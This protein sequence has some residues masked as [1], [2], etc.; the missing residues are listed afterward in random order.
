MAFDY[1]TVKIL[2]SWSFRVS[3]ARISFINSVIDVVDKEAFR[4]IQL[5]SV[6]FRRTR[7]SRLESEAFSGQT[8]VKEVEFDGVNVQY[9]AGQALSATTN[10]T[11]KD[12]RYI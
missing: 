5:E 10:F 2:P 4:A 1:V 8:S 11:I 9:V 7:I 3:G 12:S 6:H